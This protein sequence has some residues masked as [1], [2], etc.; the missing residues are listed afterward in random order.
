MSY[1]QM[2]LMSRYQRSFLLL[3]VQDCPTLFSDKGEWSSIYNKIGYTI[4]F[5]PLSFFD[6]KMTIYKRELK[7]RYKPEPGAVYE[8]EL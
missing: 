1:N 7:L 8:F 6:E 3:C 2:L 5:D 4:I